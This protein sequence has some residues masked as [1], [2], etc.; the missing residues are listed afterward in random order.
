MGK[1]KIYE[2]IVTENL[3]K[4]DENSKLIKLKISTSAT[5]M[6]ISKSHQ[7]KP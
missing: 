3:S 5:N 7:G 1:E 4:I 6:N 2:D